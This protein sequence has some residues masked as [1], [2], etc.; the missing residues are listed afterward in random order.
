MTNCSIDFKITLSYKNNHA[1]VKTNQSM[2]QSIVEKV[3]L[4]NDRVSKDKSIQ[5]S[6]VGRQLLWCKDRSCDKT[7][8]KNVSLDFTHLMSLQCC[9]AF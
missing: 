8:S 7:L 6:A 2:S 5:L 4:G 1:S 3:S 9:V